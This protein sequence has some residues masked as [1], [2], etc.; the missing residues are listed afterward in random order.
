MQGFFSLG[1]EAAFHFFHVFGGQVFWFYAAFVQYFPHGEVVVHVF[2]LD[3][4]LAVQVL[5]HFHQF[6]RKIPL[7]RFI[8][9]P[10]DINARVE[11]PQEALATV[12]SEIK[13]FLRNFLS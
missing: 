11:V 3:G 2:A 7:P 1:F 10:Q 5:F 4:G 9:P 13:L 6:R 8:Q 12:F